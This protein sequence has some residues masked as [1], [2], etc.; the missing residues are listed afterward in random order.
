MV[1]TGMFQIVNNSVM[2]EKL[3]S[4]KKVIR[5]YWWAV[6][7]LALVAAIT[8]AAVYGYGAYS[9][10]SVT[11]YVAVSDE[12]LPSPTPPD[13][14]RPVSI[15][16]MGYGGGTH[17]GG[18]LTDTMIIARV[19]PRAETVHVISL[20][21]DLWVGLPIEADGAESYWKI[22]AAYAIGSDDAKYPNKPVQYTGEAGGG[23]L[24]KY[25]VSK[26]L[27]I[28]IDYFLTLN[29]YGFEKSIDALGGVTVNVERT[30]DDPLYPIEGKEN[31]TCEKSP[32][33]LLA[34]EAT[35]SAE[36]AEKL[37]PC[38]FETLHFDRGANTMDGATAL[39]YVRSRHSNQDGGDF[40]RSNRQRNLLQA[41]KERVLEVN[42]LPKALPFIS[43][44][45]QNVRTDI[46]ASA[47]QDFISKYPE[48]KDFHIS[49]IAI[50]DKNIL[51]N[52]RS[53][54]GQFIVIPQAGADA[55]P[56]LHAWLQE[57]LTMVATPSAKPSPKAVRVE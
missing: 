27:G 16:L 14:L 29:F 24:A 44:L 57:Q 37:F 10:I 55:W 11:P 34:I 47:M 41:V 30:F 5:Q 35:A 38:R 1:A 17:A 26:V 56:S 18:L 40:G 2:S 39:K 51:Q 3:N 15:L 13:P 50:N 9:Q 20:P 25:A 36:Q 21:R 7:P 52:S 28:P 22:N 49:S 45:R 48:Y 42:F 32:E 12:P 54:N 46:S 19:N 43:T 31:E 6:I 8:A 4:L 53:A 33:E 23:E